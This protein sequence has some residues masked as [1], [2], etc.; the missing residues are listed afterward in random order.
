MGDSST[1]GLAGRH[2]PGR[3]HGPGHEDADRRWA[4]NSSIYFIIC[5]KIIFFFFFE[6]TLTARNL[7]RLVSNSLAQPLAS[8]FQSVGSIGISPR[9]WPKNAHLR[10]NK[11]APFTLAV[12][13]LPPPRLRFAARGLS[14]P[15]LVPFL[16]QVLNLE[17]L[18]R[19]WSPPLH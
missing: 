7:P 6:D 11:A 12:L 9:A 1:P 5:T 17:P 10:N 3:V 2:P 16:L 19:L 14:L 15:S 13:Q 8:A 18:V 4:P